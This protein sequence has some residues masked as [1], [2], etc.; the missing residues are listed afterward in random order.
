LFCIDEYGDVILAE[1]DEPMGL[2]DKPD[3]AGNIL[4]KN[5]KEIKT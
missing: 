1:M 4:K 5:E 2:S 3:D